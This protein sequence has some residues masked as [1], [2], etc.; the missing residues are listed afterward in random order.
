MN[1]CIPGLGWNLLA[2][3]PCGIPFSLPLP[4]VLE[5]GPSIE[6]GFKVQIEKTSYAK[7]VNADT[8]AAL[9]P[10]LPPVISQFESSS[11]P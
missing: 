6:L 9:P 8:A 10:E 11:S 5:P 4:L 7:Q 1:W 2:A 3:E